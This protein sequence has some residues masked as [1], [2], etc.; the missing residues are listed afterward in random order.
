MRYVSPNE[1]AHRLG[2]N[3]RTVQRWCRDRRVEHCRTPT[4][5]IRFTPEQADAAAEAMLRVPVE[6]H[7]GVEVPNPL[8]D[9]MRASVVPIRGNNPAA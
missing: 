2:V 7:A 1:L 8:F 3:P 4:G 5:R 9:S 6:R